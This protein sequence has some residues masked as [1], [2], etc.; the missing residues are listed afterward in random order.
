MPTSHTTRLAV[1][2]TRLA[3]D[4][5]Q[6]ARQLA[7][8]EH[9]DTETLLPG[10]IYLLAT[11]LDEL[12]NALYLAEKLDQSHRREDLATARATAYPSQIPLAA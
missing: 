7:A 12:E 8:E 10:A 2:L 5:D 9:L 11:A 1:Q 6:V 4:V 3:L